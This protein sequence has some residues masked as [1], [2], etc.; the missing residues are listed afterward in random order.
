VEKKIKPE[1]SYNI[2]EKGFQLGVSWRSHV[3]VFR[4]SFLG[5]DEPGSSSNH[6]NPPT[7]PQGTVIYSLSLL[8]KDLIIP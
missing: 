7:V 2:D 8:M 6:R 5:R 3:V 4:R 1:N